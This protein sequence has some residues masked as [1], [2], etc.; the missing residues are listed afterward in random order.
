MMFQ[1]FGYDCTSKRSSA[2]RPGTTSGRKLCFV[3][4]QKMGLHQGP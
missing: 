1:L 3:T 2:S 4:G